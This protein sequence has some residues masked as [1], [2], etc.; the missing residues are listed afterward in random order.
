MN[1]TSKPQSNATTTAPATINRTPFTAADIIVSFDGAMEPR[2]SPKARG[3]WGFVV[4]KPDGTELWRESALIPAGSCRSNNVAEY[5]AL[6]KA[7][8][9]VRA[10]R[11]ANPGASVLFQGDSRL[12][13]YHC[14]EVWGWNKKKT[15]WKPHADAPHLRT[16]LE[17]ALG[18]LR[19][20]RPLPNPFRCE[21]EP[22]PKANDLPIIWVRGENNPA[23]GESREPL[24]REGLWKSGKE[25][26]PPAESKICLKCGFD[27]T[28][29]VC[30][31]TDPNDLPCMICGDNI[32][33]QAESGDLDAQAEAERVRNDWCR[34][35]D[36][37]EGLARK[38]LALQEQGNDEPDT[39]NPEIRKIGEYLGENGDLPRI[40][41]VARRVQQLGGS[42]RWLEMNWNGTCGLMA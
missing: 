41:R 17:Q 32:F 30:F 9:W 28:P 11:T 2:N 24:I 8:D 40:F 27:M 37:D 10:W 38:L 5:T 18:G 39:V 42:S 29:Y 20:L 3:S 26:D 31:A 19:E 21:P 35:G 23:D 1:T 14:R 13:V 22:H 16:L 15:V 12:V 36:E 33:Q 6:L 25:A 4:R 34:L 7:L